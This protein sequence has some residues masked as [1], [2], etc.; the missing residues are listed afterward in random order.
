MGK[1]RQYLCRDCYVPCET[2]LPEHNPRCAYRRGA[3]LRA[4]SVTLRYLLREA[5]TDRHATQ[6]TDWL[7]EVGALFAE[8]ATDGR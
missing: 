3:E 1:T 8:E 5:Y 7:D 4:E 6:R 2:S